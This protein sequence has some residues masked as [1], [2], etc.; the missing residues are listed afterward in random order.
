MTS[1]HGQAFDDKFNSIV[2]KLS[3]MAD[4]DRDDNNNDSNDSSD[5]NLFTDF[6]NWCCGK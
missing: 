5:Q 4:D 3:S 1:Q 6:V 2:N